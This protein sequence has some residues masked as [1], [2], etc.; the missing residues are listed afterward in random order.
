[1]IGVAA[2]IRWATSNATRGTTSSESAEPARAVASSS[3]P[4][5]D[6][7]GPNRTCARP[8]RRDCAR[9]NRT[10][11]ARLSGALVPPDSSTE[12]AETS[13]CWS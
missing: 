10:T 8:R 13:C 6:S 11:Q 1:V 9:A 12:S 7:G 2:L 4:R 3:A 5:N